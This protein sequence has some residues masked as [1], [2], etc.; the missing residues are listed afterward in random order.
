MSFA[1]T[2]ATT[3]SLQ[4]PSTAGELVDRLGP[5]PATLLAVWAHPDDESYLGAGLMAEIARRGGRVVNVTASF[6]EHG[7]EDTN[8]HPPTA[9]AVQRQRELGAALKKLGAEHGVILGYPDGG[10]DQTSDPMGA[11]RI[12]SII[13]DV[14]PDVVLTFGHDGVTG[15]PDHRAIARW[16]ELAVA[17]R[18]NRIPLVTTASGAVWPDSLV[19][20][21]HQVGAFWPGYPER[22]VNGPVVP[23]RL[24]GDLLD[25][26]MSALASHES[27]IGPLLDVLGAADYRR[28]AS[29][30]AYR[31][32][33]PAATA[34]LAELLSAAAA[35]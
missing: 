35:A 23:V 13:D 1:I 11:R 5:S 34:R 17:E 2:S 3:S 33:N 19:D 12:G 10:C 4:I 26:K 32:A 9:M 24:Q 28:L 14:K 15:H 31:P 6:G 29:V 16:T 18:T 25:R 7:A 21:M 27:Q 30:E 20:R 22:S 8:L